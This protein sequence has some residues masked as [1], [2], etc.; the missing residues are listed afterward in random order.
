MGMAAEKIT[1]KAVY[2]ARPVDVREIDW[3]RLTEET[4][5][6]TKVIRAELAK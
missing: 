5:E 6:Q 2:K 3:D 4:R 1:P